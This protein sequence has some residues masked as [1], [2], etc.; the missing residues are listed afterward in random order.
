M[1]IPDSLTHLSSAAAVCVLAS[2]KINSGDSSVVHNLRLRSMFLL[3]FYKLNGA[4]GREIWA[5]GVAVDPQT[6]STNIE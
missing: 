6:F 3:A 1:L 4:L 5:C 2:M